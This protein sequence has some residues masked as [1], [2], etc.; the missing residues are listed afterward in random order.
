M[1]HVKCCYTAQKKPLKPSPR[2]G[3]HSSL[4]L[5]IKVQ[6]LQTQLS[7]AKQSV[8]RADSD[9]TDLGAPCKSR[10]SLGSLLEQRNFPPW[11]EEA[12]QL[13]VTRTAAFKAIV[14]FISGISDGDEGSYRKESIKD[15][16]LIKNH[17]F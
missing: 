13:V 8:E 16:L 5:L 1:S 2:M 6:C 9:A 3:S 10:E 11:I 7:V 14:L 12:A 4:F 15:H 17:P